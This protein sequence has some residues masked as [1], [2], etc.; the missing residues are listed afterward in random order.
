MAQMNNSEDVQGWIAQ[1]PEA[2]AFSSHTMVGPIPKVAGVH[3]VPIMLLRDP[4][5]RIHSAYRF[6]RNQQADT[7]GAQ[8]AKEHDFEG[9][10]QARLAREGDR[11][12]RNF[13]TSRLAALLPGPED[14]IDRAL[15]A[16]TQLHLTG[17]I[18]TIDRFGEAVNELKR[19]I[20]PVYGNFEP[21]VTRENVSGTVST[22]ASPDVGD[23]LHDANLDDM[24]VVATV[25]SWH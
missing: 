24:R 9:Y 4:I 25:Q 18:D 20:A 13:Q 12:C 8:L 23:A 21:K 10:V 11:Q 3:I 14:E 2:I 5:A 7:W 16:A 6:E 19:R 15:M 17:V 22:A 1:N